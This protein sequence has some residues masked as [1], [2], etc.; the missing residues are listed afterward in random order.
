MT[1]NVGFYDI[2]KMCKGGLC[3]SMPAHDSSTINRRVVIPWDVKKVRVPRTYALGIFIDSTLERMYK[4]GEF[5]IEPVAQFEREVASIFFPVE[6]K[7][8]V[9]TEEEIKMA[10]IK[11]NRKAIKDWLNENSVNRD[12]VIIIARECIGE[13]PTSMVKDLQD[14]LEVELLV[15]NE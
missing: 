13:I 3:L 12:N 2:V 10:L 1:E 6:N 15:E 11:G 8:Q 9:A 4:A 5:R 14:I 7:A